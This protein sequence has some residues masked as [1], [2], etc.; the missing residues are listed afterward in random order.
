MSVGD[1]QYFLRCV[2][3]APY[4][5]IRSYAPDHLVRLGSRRLMR[6]FSEFSS[7]NQ[8]RIG[9][10][11]IGCGYSSTVPDLI[12]IFSI[13]ESS[14]GLSLTDGYSGSETCDMLE[15]VSTSLW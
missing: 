6:A 8:W 11:V 9:G 13:S 10:F 4:E 1:K 15:A 7:Q 12:T 5:L 14:D 3:G 2:L